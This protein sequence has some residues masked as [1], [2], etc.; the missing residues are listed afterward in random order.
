MNQGLL[1]SRYRVADIHSTGDFLQNFSYL[2][3]HSTNMAK[4][5]G[6]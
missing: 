2:P 6:D 1:A 3:N 4:L 5:K